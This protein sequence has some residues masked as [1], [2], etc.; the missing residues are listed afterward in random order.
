MK[1]NLIIYKK[2][3]EFVTVNCKFCKTCKSYKEMDDFVGSQEECFRCVYKRKL[4]NAEAEP[5]KEKNCKICKKA[6]AKQR[7]AYCSQECLEK[8]IEENKHWSLK[9]TRKDKSKGWKGKGKFD[10]RRTAPSRYYPWNFK[11]NQ[12]S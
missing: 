2:V 9:F 8:S 11:E 6:L 7:W 10:I 3:K 12:E 4:L 5:A 1:K